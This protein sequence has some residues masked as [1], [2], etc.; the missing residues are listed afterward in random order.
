MKMSIMSEDQE[1]N[2]ICSWCNKFLDKKMVT[3]PSLFMKNEG[4][5]FVTHGICPECK[6]QMEASDIIET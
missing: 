4:G 6:E 3:A 5:I 2:V 1:V